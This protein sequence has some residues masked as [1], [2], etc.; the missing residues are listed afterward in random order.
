MLSSGL[1]EYFLKTYQ[2]SDI[3]FLRQQI[4]NNVGTGKVYNLPNSHIV[5]FNNISIELSSV[6][7]EL[8]K[9]LNFAK[10]IIPKTEDGQPTSS[11]VDLSECQAILKKKYNLPEE[12]DLLVIKADTLEELNLTE[13]LGIET[14]YQLFSYSLGAFLPLSACKDENASVTVTNPFIFNDP[15]YPLQSKKT[16]SVLSNGYDA[17]DAY[18]PFYNDICTPFTNENGNDVLLDARR[19]DYYNENINICESGCIFIG[20]NTKSMTYICKCNIKTTPGESAGEYTGEI[21]E[22]S[23]PE[24]F[25]DLISKRSNIEVFKCASNVFSA[26]GQKKNFGSYI[27][28]AGFAAFIGVVVFHCVKEKGSTEI[29]KEKRK[30]KMKKKRKKRKIKKKEKKKIKKKRRRRKKIKF[31]IQKRKYMEYL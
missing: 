6:K 13:Y 11:G 25:K 23:L 1:A 18:S 28:L 20:Y 31:K 7:L 17:F 2:G 15:L 8:E 30:K 21:V 26:E 29:Y 14:N 4:I 12:E 3:E 16:S 5:A 19:K 27:L 22:R 9:I 24:N 10:G